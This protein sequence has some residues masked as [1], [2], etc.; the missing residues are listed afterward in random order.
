MTAEDIVDFNNE[1]T[2]STARSAPSI[3]SVG[4]CQML[5]MMPII[6]FTSIQQLTLNGINS[7]FVGVDHSK[8]KRRKNDDN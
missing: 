8:K 1:N 5:F 6:L 2:L 7:N 4:T 3:A